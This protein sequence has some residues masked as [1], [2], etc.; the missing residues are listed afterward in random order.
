MVELR[1]EA[2]NGSHRGKLDAMWDPACNA[3]TIRNSHLRIDTTYYLHN[4]GTYT[5]IVTS[6]NEAS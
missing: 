1:T 6:L 3:I 2:I 5:S 4:D